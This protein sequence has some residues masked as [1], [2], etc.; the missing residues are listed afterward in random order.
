MMIRYLAICHP[1]Y[2]YTM[3]GLKRTARFYSYQNV[4][5]MIMLVLAVYIDVCRRTFADNYRSFLVALAS[6]VL[7]VRLTNP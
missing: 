5:I 1:L 3:A 6:L 2:S 4:M 7:D